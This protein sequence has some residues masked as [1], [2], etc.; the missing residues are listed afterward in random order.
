MVTTQINQSFTQADGTDPLRFIVAYQGLGSS[1][2]IY[3][4]ALRLRT[5]GQ[6]WSG[7]DQIT[8]KYDTVV[9]DFD[10]IIELRDGDAT[11]KYVRFQYHV[12]GSN[13]DGERGYT[14]DLNQEN[15]QLYVSASDYNGQPLGLPIAFVPP[16]PG[17]PYFLRASCIA[18][19]HKIKLWKGLLGD[20]PIAG[21]LDGNGW[22][23]V[24]TDTTLT[25]GDWGFTHGVGGE[26]IVRDF[27]FDN[28]F[29][30]GE[31]TVQPLVVNA[32]L[33]RTVDPNIVDTFE[34]VAVASSGLA[35][36][37][38]LW[39]DIT[40]TPATIAGSG[41]SRTVPVPHSALSLT[42]TY[43]V[44]VTDSGGATVIDTVAITF[45]PHTRWRKTTNSLVALRRYA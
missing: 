21:G 15:P 25:S 26:A 40:S 35:I 3:S 31:G 8:C 18:G 22:Q 24:V 13:F 11:E 32:G 17:V 12:G 45:L 1:A 38:Y 4:N 10:Q 20:Q 44:S 19:E 7:A 23:I 27:F 2:K 33:D 5:D 6:G 39:E 14:F 30:A 37:S 36:T 34:L 28:I 29:A 43:R 42:K 16:V 9:D 41:P